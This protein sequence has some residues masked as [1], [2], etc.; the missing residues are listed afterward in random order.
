[1]V[2]KC[3]CVCCVCVSVVCDVCVVYLACVVCVC[4]CVVRVVSAVCDVGSFVCWSVVALLCVLPRVSALFHF[5]VLNA[6]CY[7]G[8]LW[9]VHY[10]SCVLCLVG[11]VLCG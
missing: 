3:V 11:G 9:C 2:V 10:V 7:L 1:M 4:V 6:V 8:V 5:V